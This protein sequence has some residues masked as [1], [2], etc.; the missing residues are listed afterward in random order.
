MCQHVPPEVLLVL[1]GEATLIALVGPQTG[2]LCHVSLDRAEAR[3]QW[4]SMKGSK[5]P[6]ELNHVSL[7][8][9]IA[10]LIGIGLPQTESLKPQAALSILCQFVAVL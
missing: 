8:I 6:R 1:G 5:S 7:R 10:D 4:V 9:K 3:R 2:V